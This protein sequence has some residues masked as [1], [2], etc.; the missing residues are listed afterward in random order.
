MINQTVTKQTES[1]TENGTK[2]GTSGGVKTG[3]DTPTAPLAAVCVISLVFMAVAL[4]MG[5]R[6]RKE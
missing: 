1:E 5:K 6:K 3:D 2:P 4:A